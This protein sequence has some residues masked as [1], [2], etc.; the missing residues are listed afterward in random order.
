V[1]AFVGFAGLYVRDAPV[2]RK[3]GQKHSALIGAAV[4]I[5]AGK[6][7]CPE[8]RA[9]APTAREESKSKAAGVSDADGSKVPRDVF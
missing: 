5:T 4:A 7:I 8:D 3:Q 2:K 9:A 6:K 1:N